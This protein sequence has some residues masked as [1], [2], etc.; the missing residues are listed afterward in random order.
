[1]SDANKTKPLKA[2]ETA[3]KVLL[4][5]I[6]S[7]PNIA[8]IWNKYEQDALGEFIKERQIISFAWK[9]LHEKEV[10]CLSLPMLPTY[11]N[12][13]DDNKDL[14][15]KLHN[16]MSQADIVVGHN[17]NKFDDP[18]SNSEFIRHGLKPP[19]PHK[20]IDTLQFARHKFRFNSNKLGDL[21]KRLNLGDKINTGGF[22]LWAK[23][24]RGDPGAWA[25]MALYNMGD[26]SLLEKIYLKMRPWMTKHPNMN[27]L[28]GIS[29]CPTCKSPIIKLQSRGRV[30]FGSGWKR[31]FQCQQCGKWCRGEVIK[32]SWRFK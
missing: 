24:L 29:A 17:I 15:L 14:I 11:K 16:L 19:P 32:N 10:H 18:M 8:Y 1:M 21:G 27:S 5:D 31:Q 2:A 25:K 12:D 9:W 6:E 22:D 7:S 20:T 4:Y 30:I 23:C 28:D 26:V 3:V 13:P